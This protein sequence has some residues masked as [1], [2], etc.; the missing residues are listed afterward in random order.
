MFKEKGT[1]KLEFDEVHFA[2]DSKEL[3]AKTNNAPG[4]VWQPATS[5]R[6]AAVEVEM[7]VPSEIELGLG[8]DEE[9]GAPLDERPPF[10]RRDDEEEPRLPLATIREAET[11]LLSSAVQRAAWFSATLQVVNAPAEGD[12]ILGVMPARAVD[13]LKQ[14]GWYRNPPPVIGPSV[15]LYPAWHARPRS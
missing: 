3:A 4:L 1:S 12:I 5:N 14:P 6:P 2:K 7:V 13:V 11:G 8:A 10:G 9:G 15:N